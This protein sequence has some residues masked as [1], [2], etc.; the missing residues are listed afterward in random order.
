M[1]HSYKHLILTFVQHIRGKDQLQSLQELGKR[2]TEKSF[3]DLARD[4]WENPSRTWQEMCGRILQELGK[5]CMGESFKDLARDAWENP[6]RTWQEMHGR[7]LQGL[8]KRCVGESFK[9]LARDAW[10]NLEQ[11]LKK[12][13]NV[14][15]N[16]I[17]A[18]RNVPQN[19]M[20]FC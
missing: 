1:N 4:A 14:L 3:K 11:S 19:S 5:R 9:N 12:L 8:G 6:S 10:E 13:F 20:I 18:F 17:L 7:I 2:Y 16:R 15:P